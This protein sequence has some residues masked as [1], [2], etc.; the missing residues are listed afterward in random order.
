MTGWRKYQID[1]MNH[2]QR[3][4]MASGWICKSETFEFDMKKQKNS[5]ENLEKVL[6]QENNDFSP[7]FLLQ[8]Y[9]QKVSNYT[10]FKKNFREVKMRC[11][12][13]DRYQVFSTHMNQVLSLISSKNPE[14]I[15]NYLPKNRDLDQAIVFL[16]KTLK[17]SPS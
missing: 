12:I 17:L 6:L 10:A 13:I 7:S 11:D 15:K 16:V 3:N 14:K 8:A 1:E 2:S 4:S 5:I 9:L